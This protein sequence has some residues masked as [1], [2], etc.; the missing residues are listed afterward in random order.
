MRIDLLF[1]TI[2]K[3]ENGEGRTN[4][5]KEINATTLNEK[6]QLRESLTILFVYTPLCGTCKLAGSMLDVIETSYPSLVIH[7]LNINHAPTFA[8]TWKIKS[9]PS[10]LVFQKGLGVER[11]YAFQSISHLHA[12]IKPY[13]VFAELQIKR[14]T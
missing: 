12:M 13:A 2:R 9:V 14:S 3:K 1:A 5:M 10:L 7:K 4:F 6:L 11:I 8:Q